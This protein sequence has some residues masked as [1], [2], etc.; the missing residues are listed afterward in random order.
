MFPR[1]SLLMGQSD[2][3]RAANNLLPAI[4]MA[5]K[6]HDMDGLAKQ[7]Q[8]KFNKISHYWTSQSLWVNLLLN[9]M[10]H[11]YA[12]YSQIMHSAVVNRWVSKHWDVCL[13]I[14]ISPHC[15][16]VDL[17]Q[18]FKKCGTQISGERM[19]FHNVAK[20]AG[21]VRWAIPRRKR[22]K[23]CHLCWVMWCLELR[24]SVAWPVL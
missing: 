14:L 7:L 23:Q 13:F 21:V 17:Q 15:C 18:T 8:G 20:S 9:T 22:F 16:L 11:A 5:M 3:P 4:S 10:L 1:Q 24:L 2:Q 19:K 6:T 12:F